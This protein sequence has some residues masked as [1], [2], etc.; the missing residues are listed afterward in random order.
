MQIPIASTVTLVMELFI[1]TLIF[2]IVYGGY[3]KNVFSKKLT[4]FA[5]A[6]ETVFNVGYMIYRTVAAPST[7]NLGSGLKIVAAM[8]GMLSLVMLVVVI[9]FFLRA[10]R[11][12]A[13]GIN[14]FR[15]HHIQAKVFL[16]CWIV[17]LLSGIFLY[18]KVYF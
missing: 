6:Y 16:V 10:T 17:S 13:K 2:Y 8:H 7:V 12:Y 4:F 5:I 15:V 9:L 11:E 14:S 3:A 18:L 1:A